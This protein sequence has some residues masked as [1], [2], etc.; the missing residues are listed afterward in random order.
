[1][2]EKGIAWPESIAPAEYYVI[3]LWEE[4]LK[5]A[6]EYVKN[7]EK[8]GKKVI[9]DDRISKK[10]WFGQKMSDAEL[11]GV[12]NIVIFSDKTKDTEK[13]YEIEIRGKKW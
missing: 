6:D 1:M 10:I 12:K 11:L 9:F 13:W 2:D 8:K 5:R 4:S 7:L 3:A